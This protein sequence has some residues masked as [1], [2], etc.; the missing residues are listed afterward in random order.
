MEGDW[1][2]CLGEYDCHLRTPH[3]WG[4]GER[5]FCLLWCSFVVH[6]QLV[7]SVYT[8]PTLKGILLC[9]VLCSIPQSAL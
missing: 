7:A 5:Q 9:W 1:E 3:D 2:A 8:L 6:L 4:G